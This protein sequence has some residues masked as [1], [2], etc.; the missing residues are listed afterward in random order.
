MY[1]NGNILDNLFDLT[2]ESGVLNTLIGLHRLKEMRRNG[3]INAALIL[4]D[5]Y[6]SLER[7]NLT[8]RQRV[9]IELVFD[10][11]MWQEEAGEIL[12][13]TQQGISYHITGAIKRIAKYNRKIAGGNI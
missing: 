13:L 8:D 1:S 3:N 5:F 12:G 2:K 11:G 4:L 6:D 7:A 9:C 10:K